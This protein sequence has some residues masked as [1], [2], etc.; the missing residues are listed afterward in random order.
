MARP[1][2]YSK[3]YVPVLAELMARCG[4]IDKDM[5]KYIGVAESTFHKWKI[6]HPE[7]AA[8][9]E[10]GKKVADDEVVAALKKSAIG[11][12]V[13]EITQRRDA[14]GETIGTTLSKRWVPGSTGSMCFWLKNRDPENWRDK[15]E[16][17]IDMAN[18]PLLK[19]AEAMAGFRLPED[20]GN[21]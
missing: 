1:T 2:K 20:A 4:M 10:K 21:S 12:Y 13:E 5:A 19:F 17:E 18:D 9:L 15:Q 3:N 6:D 7:F 11:Y 14:D 8:S 16:I